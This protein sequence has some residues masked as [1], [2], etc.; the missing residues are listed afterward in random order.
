MRAIATDGSANEL[1]VKFRSSTPGFITAIRFYRGSTGG[2]PFVANLWSGT[3]EWLASATLNTVSTVGWQQLLLCK[4]CGHCLQT[5]PTLLRTS[6]L[7]TTTILLT[8]T[9]FSTSGVENL[10]LT[11]LQSGIDGANGVF[12]APGTFPTGT[13]RDS[14]YWVDVLFDVEATTDTTPP[15]I[16]HACAADVGAID[17][18]VTTTVT[19]QFSEPMDVATIG[20]STITLRAAGAGADVAA[21]VTYNAASNTATLN[22]NIDLTAG[23]LYTAKVTTGVTDLAGNALATEQT[24]SF[25]TAA[26]VLPTCPCSIWDTSF[27]P[28]SAPVNDQGQ[29]IEVGT[30]F[31][32]SV[33]GQIT[34]L[35][36]Y[37]GA[38]DDDTHVGHLWSSTGAQ[39]AEVSFT[40]ESASGWQEMALPTPIA[41]LPNTTYIASIFSSPT[42]NFAITPGGLAAARDNPP[43]RALA[44]DEDGKN[45]V[46]K[47]GGGFPDGP[48][49]DG[50]TNYWVDVVFDTNIVVDT[51]P[52]T[53]STRSPGVDATD[54]PINANVT[55]QFSEAMKVSTIDGATFTLR[56]DGAGTDVNAVV[57]YSGVTAILNPS[58]D[59]LP[60][61][62]YHVTVAGT[63]ADLSDNALGAAVTWSFTTAAPPPFPM[64]TRWR[65]LPRARPARATWRRAATAR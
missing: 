44:N 59:L 10:P 21:A 12:G 7:P 39:L 57:S 63:V 65:T 4:S 43:L 30:K 60:S 2:G 54:V 37:R 42:G 29:P 55:V 32:S 23:T 61:T 1:G 62:L 35:R 15:T 38:G 33:A 41:I 52:P 64:M 27:V 20:A 5:Q 36:Y 58:A 56:A 24:W 49:S 16:V 17:M 47:Y 51:T 6:C 14:N 3:G 26:V 50:G 25:T 40:G 48:V 13:Y 22:P 8:G 19:V 53:I 46:F 18:P 28:Q 34:A 11:A 9:Y 31:R 45:G